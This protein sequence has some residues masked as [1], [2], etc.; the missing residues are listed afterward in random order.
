MGRAEHSRVIYY[1][2]RD[3]VMSKAVAMTVMPRLAQATGARGPPGPAVPDGEPAQSL[4]EGV[5]RAPVG[6]V[7]PQQGESVQGGRQDELELGGRSGGA[8]RSKMCSGQDVIASVWAGL[9]GKQ[10]Y[11]VT[12]GIS[13]SL[14]PGADGGMDCK[15]I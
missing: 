1:P 4:C 15:G 5:Q 6:T 10:S 11:C 12:K 3:P 9:I 14:K 7:S 13:G 8:S 2:N